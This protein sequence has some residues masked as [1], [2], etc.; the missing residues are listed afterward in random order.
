MSRLVGTS[1]LTAFIGTYSATKHAIEAI[2]WAMKE[3]LEPYGIKVAT[4]NPGPY[5]TGFNDTGA[6]S[7]LQWYDPQSD[8]I[9]LPEAGNVLAHQFNPQE[10]VDVMV[11]VIP[12]DHH[13]FRTVY[14]EE[15]V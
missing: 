14:P 6:V 1:L 2:A 5:L 7:M 12:S 15:M 8:L 4:I 3:E 9:K 10:M 11:K 13:P